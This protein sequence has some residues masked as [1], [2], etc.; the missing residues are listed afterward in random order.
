MRRH[1]R[2]KGQGRLLA[3]SSEVSRGPGCPRDEGA[4]VTDIDGLLEWWK[5]KG[6]GLRA[7]YALPG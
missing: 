1:Q 3:S 6:L 2:R 5:M 4:R 7:S